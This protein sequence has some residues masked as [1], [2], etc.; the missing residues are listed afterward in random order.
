MS[1][2][3]WCGYQLPAGTTY[4]LGSRCPGCKRLLVVEP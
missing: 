1:S 2:C 3:A 4:P